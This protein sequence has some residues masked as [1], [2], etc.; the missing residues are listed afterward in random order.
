MCPKV[1]SQQLWNALEIK[2]VEEEEVNPFLDCTSS[3]ISMNGKS[4][5]H[6]NVSIQDEITSLTSSVK[7]VADKI[8][9]NKLVASQQA[10]TLKH[11]RTKEKS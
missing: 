3:E 9:T 6:N 5:I 8:F 1:P 10:T 7:I 2:E 4:L 11:I